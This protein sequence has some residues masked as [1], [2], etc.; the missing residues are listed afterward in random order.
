ME[1]EVTIDELLYVRW[2]KSTLRQIYRLEEVLNKFSTFKADA[3]KA[4]TSV[5]YLNLREAAWPSGRVVRVPDLK[6][7]DPEFKSRPDHQLD[8][9]QV[10]LGSTPR[11]LLYIANWF[12]SCQLGFLS[13]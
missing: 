3:E 2:F 11:L 4:S 13:C 10:V 9:S 7:G 6:S 8:L 1:I 12:A 5:R